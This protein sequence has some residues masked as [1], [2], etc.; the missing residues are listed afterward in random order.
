MTPASRLAIFRRLQ[1]ANP[2][3]KT[4]LVYRSTFQLLVTV[5]LSAQATD[6]S[7]NKATK[8]L[9]K[10]ANTPEGLLKLGEA[11]LKK[12]IRTIGL[13]NTKAKNILRTCRILLDEY[14]GEVPADRK[15]LEALPGVGRKTA[16]IVMNIAFG[17]PTIAVDTHVFRVCNR[18]GLAP[19]K[20]PRAVE[21]RLVACTPEAFKLDAHHWLILHGRHVCKARKP[22][23]PNC[24]IAAYCEYP[25]KTPPPD[26]D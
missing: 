15:A 2:R 26:E 17:V 24:V 19:G 25:H 8:P 16:N 6:V 11:G 10:V 22:D 7:V 5:I 12:Y 14:G 4:E 23:C 9:F 18:T 3:P 13:Y 21:D 20:T 1:K